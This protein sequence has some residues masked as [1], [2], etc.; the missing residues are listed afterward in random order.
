MTIFGDR[1]KTKE[2]L[3]EEVA[4]VKHDEVSDE[5]I[6]GFIHGF[7]RF[8]QQMDYL[9]RDDSG[10]LFRFGEVLLSENTEKV[11]EN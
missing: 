4:Q 11:N 10:E 8:A 6:E 7:C 5:Y 1:K 9:N 2:M 3:L